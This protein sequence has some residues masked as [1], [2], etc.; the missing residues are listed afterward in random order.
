M[1]LPRLTQD[2]TDYWCVVAFR[3][4]GLKA[5]AQLGKRTPWAFGKPLI[6]AHE[7]GST[8]WIGTSGLLGL[9]YDQYTWSGWVGLQIFLPVAGT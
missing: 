9:Q 5:H 7:L 8:Y 3:V 1:W 6:L 4:S 2:A